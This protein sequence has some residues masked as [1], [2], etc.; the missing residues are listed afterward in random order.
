MTIQCRTS[1][2]S[3]VAISS[4]LIALG[5]SAKTALQQGLSAAYQD[6]L[7]HHA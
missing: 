4:K 3:K 7:Q 2:Q 1:K 5:W 6:F